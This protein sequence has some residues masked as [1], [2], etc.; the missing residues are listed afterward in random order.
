MPPSWTAC[1]IAWSRLCSEMMPVLLI[2]EREFRTYVSA[3]SF[4]I[5]LLIGPLVM[6]AALAVSSLSARPV[7]VSVQVNLPQNPGGLQL[8]RLAEGAITEAGRM[9]GRQFVFPAAGA[10]N[11][12]VLERHGSD[13]IA[14][15][16]DAGFP[17]TGEG[18]ALVAR[19]LERDRM[20]AHEPVSAARGHWLAVNL[21][22]ENDLRSA[23]STRIV[24][25]TL[26]AILWF[27]L[28]GS[29]GMLLQAV[30]RERA[31]RALEALLA[32]AR[33]FEIVTGKL[34][35]VG[36][37]S[38]LVLGTWLV[39]AAILS[40]A[41][42][43]EGG[44]AA[45]VLAEIAAPGTLLRGVAVYIL[46]WGFYGLVAIGIGAS[47][48]DSAAAQNFS[49]P[50]F[51]VLLLVFL[52]ALVSVSGAG[53]RL[54]WL[55]YIAPFTPFMLLLSAPGEIPLAAQVSALLLLLIAGVGAAR[56]AAGRLTLSP[57][58]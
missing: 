15:R 50:M 48:R 22:G 32:A 20:R 12:L 53:V 26:V 30:V 5:A 34:L 46:A 7:P 56:F 33:P 51:V 38:A 58:S 35:G 49:R 37:V 45:G 24:H 25:F 41:V 17:L 55:V 8:V 47:A 36:A 2:A 44:G 1:A 19:T 21:S 39:S 52:V 54:W 16:F 29:L 18:R 23:S 13:A 57:G 9:E 42:H 4:W 40:A 11:S 28:T 3:L 27:T 10:R 6:A 14:L 31:N 43:G